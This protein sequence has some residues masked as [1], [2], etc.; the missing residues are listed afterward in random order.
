MRVIR[1]NPGELNQNLIE[2]IVKNHT[3][4]SIKLGQKNME[5]YHSDKSVNIE[6]TLIDLEKS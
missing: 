3:G 2:E 1:V 5:I 6:V 4:V